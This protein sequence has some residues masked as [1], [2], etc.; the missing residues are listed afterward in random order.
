MSERTPAEATAPEP[1][2][3][4]TAGLAAATLE[5]AAGETPAAAA[6]GGM[7][8]PQVVPAAVPV[9]APAAAA[10]VPAAA[11]AT[12]AGAPAVVQPV[13]AAA[14]G[15][16]AVA[17]PA[18]G[19]GGGADPARPRNR[20]QVSREK[21]P[22]NFFIGLAK[23]FLVNEEEVELSGL[24][25]GTLCWAGGGGGG[26][27]RLAMDLSCRRRGVASR[28]DWGRRGGVNGELGAASPRRGCVGERGGG[29]G[30]ASGMDPSRIAG[31]AGAGVFG[32]RLSR[33]SGAQHN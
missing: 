12:A 19:G 6:A 27:R 1:T 31:E 9:A 14:A 25:L 8:A 2:A 23:K 17:A 3:A 32:W 4:V 13:A 33:L 22:L 16:P 26:D 7:A 15:A 28:V 29:G 11:A 30:S 24:G 21:R 18:A 5:P 10:P 20:I